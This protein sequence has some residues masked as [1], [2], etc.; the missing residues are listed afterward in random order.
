MRI[1]LFCITTLLLFVSNAK[2]QTIHR[3]ACQGDLEKL[4]SLLQE[5]SINIK[6]NL[7]RSLL[8]W[9]VACRQKEVFDLL[10]DRGINA[11]AED[12]NKETPMHIAVRFNNE[13]YFDMLLN[14]QTNKS[15][16]NQYGASLLE[17][18]VLNK[19]QTFI[20]K[21]INNGADINS[22]NTRGSTPL[23]IAIRIGAK[24]IS[25][26]LLSMGADENK[27]RAFKLKG[28]YMGQ[29]APGLTPK[30]FAPNVI[31]TEESEFGSVFNARGTEFYYGVDVNGKPEIRYSRRVNNR[32]S[33]P[34]TILT[35]ERYGY[36]DPFLSPDENR[37][38]FISKRA[39]DGSG[40]LKDHDIWY[41]ER[42]KDGWSQPINA[43]PNINSEGN[44]YYISF[45][46]DGTMYFSSNVNA[47]EERKR[48]DYD[49]YYSKFV[50]GE[51]QKAISLGKSIN[52][53]DYEADVFVAPDESYLIFCSTRKDGLGQGDLYISFK[54]ANGSWAPAVNMGNAVNTEKH[55]LCPFI[56]QDGKYLFY[57]S[58]Q[59]IYWIST[60]ILKNY[61]K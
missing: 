43:G 6:D 23:E 50:D 57:T 5:T 18:A 60:E 34:E 39:M 16:V 20:R 8:H 24:E 53:Q 52:T 58:D 40:D 35:H 45:A 61:K 22:I 11:N 47:P 12:R 13:T 31:S 51:F 2:A 21:L 10:V 26:W 27:V 28:E 32:W 29:K 46:N 36:N 7:G 49:V 1:Y 54:E 19:S 59:D 33:T 14:L 48:H 4:D 17:K 9:A 25:G 44:E 37:L 3:I 41:V 38:Y 55:E 42:E 30:M 56:T 15:W